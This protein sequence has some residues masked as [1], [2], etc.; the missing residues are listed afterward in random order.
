MSW[1]SNLNVHDQVLL[2]ALFVLALSD[3]S[4]LSNLNVHDQV[5]LVAL[6]VRDGNA[7]SF[8][9]FLVF[10]HKF[11][12]LSF[13]VGSLL[14]SSVFSV[15]WDCN[16]ATSTGDT[17]NFKFV[18]SNRFNNLSFGILKSKDTA[19][20]V[21]KNHDSGHVGGSHLAGGLQ[22]PPAILS[23]NFNLFEWLAILA[24][25]VR[26]TD[27]EVFILLKDVVIKNLKGHHLLS[28]TRSKCQSSNS[29]NIVTFAGGTSILSLVVNL[30]SLVEGSTF[31][32]NSDFK[33]SNRLHDSVVRGVEHDTGDAI[34]FLLKRGSKSSFFLGKGSLLSFS[35][36]SKLLLK[37]FGSILLTSH[38]A[39][40]LG[41]VVGTGLGS[42][43]HNLF[44]GLGF[45]INERNVGVFKTNPLHGIDIFTTVALKLSK[46][47][48]NIFIK[49]LEL[50][51]STV[52]NV[53]LL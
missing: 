27:I 48:V 6:F 31:A 51:L 38:L 37:G 42:L 45:K 36:S 7:D 35:L 33:G 47:G 8:G 50:L 46:S 53:S 5:L 29:F 44:S 17:L 4:W 41:T 20:V 52:L 14:G 32:D 18:S 9:C 43:G 21:V 3:M 13:I 26:D 12:F 10:I 23:F 39:S 28:L 24:A 30:D 2:V 49:I 40:S 11:S 16:L 22:R 1:L 15:V 19:V 25:K 34:I